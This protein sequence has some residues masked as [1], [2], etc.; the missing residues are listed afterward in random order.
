MKEIDFLL[1]NNRRWVEETESQHPG[2]FNQLSSQQHP[3]YLWIGCSDSRV[4][5]NTIVGLRPGDVFVHRNVA[6]LVLQT[7][8]NC[9]SVIE[10]AVKVLK[11]KHIL[12]CGH[13]G[14]GGVNAAL[15]NE[16]NG[17]VDNWLRNVRDVYIHHKHEVDKA[18]DEHA[19]ARRLC[20]LNVEAQV[21][22][23]CRTTIIQDT[24]ESGQE[25]TV[26]GVIYDINDGLLQDLN[27]SIRS[28]LEL[29]EKMH[30]GA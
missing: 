5:A 25:L 1:Q 16:K 7:D 18:G 30:W 23:V 4:P 28:E 21:R 9:L 6:N 17:V 22:N 12:V 10:Y 2:F 15:N 24:W 13:Y 19:R 26:H 8:L 20:E 14:C 27:I 11:V 3:E 29:E